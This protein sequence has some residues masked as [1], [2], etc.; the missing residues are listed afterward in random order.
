MKARKK[1]TIDII[2]IIFSYYYSINQ[3]QIRKNTGLQ[4]KFYVLSV[5]NQISLDDFVPNQ[6][7]WDGIHLETELETGCE[8]KLQN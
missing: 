3:N 4:H 6:Q 1:A 5:D 2:Y 8:A 7:K